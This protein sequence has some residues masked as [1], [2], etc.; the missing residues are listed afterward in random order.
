MENIKILIVDD[1]PMMR[2]AYRSLL[3]LDKNGFEVIGYVRD[4]REALDIIK[5]K[6]ADIVITDLKMP[7]MSGTELI[8]AAIAEFPDIKFIVVSGYDD[9]NLVREAYILGAKDYFLKFE[10]SHTL[11]TG[12]CLVDSILLLF[13]YKIL[14]LFK[15]Q[16]PFP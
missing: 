12:F 8:A 2:N 3:D 11:K 15:F 16:E 1:E 7:I 6:G 14:I 4:G 5:E 10:M 9:F 13:F